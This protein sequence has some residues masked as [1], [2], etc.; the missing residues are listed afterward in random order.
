MSKAVAL[1]FALVLA[2]AV[3]TGAQSLW[4]FLG[5]LGYVFP[6]S[7]GPSGYVLYNNGGGTLSWV[8]AAPG[9][10]ATMPTG[11][12]VFSTGTCAAIGYN[13]YNAANGFYPV[14]ATSGIGGT[15]GSALSNLENRP[16][17][18]HTHSVSGTVSVT[19]GSHNH[20]ISDSGHYH[21][22]DTQAASNYGKVPEWIQYG[23]PPD[24]YYDWDYPEPWYLGRTAG[25]TNSSASGSGYDI[26]DRVVSTSGSINSFTIGNGGTG[27]GTNAPYRQL[28]MCKK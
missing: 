9:G 1:V 12:I 3:S 11:I 10:S 15:T 2:L 26:T 20:S 21:T 17:G 16:T 22:D 19:N 28:R 24:E 14:G 27:T 23:D 5:P 18:L 6:T 4:N 13:D 8:A 25:N 7:D